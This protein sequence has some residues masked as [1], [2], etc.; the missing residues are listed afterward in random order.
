[1]RRRTFALT[2]C[3]RSAARSDERTEIL[4]L[5]APLA[6]A[7]AEGDAARFMRH[8]ASDMPGRSTLR[9]NIQAL[10]DQADVTSSV[11]LRRLSNGAAEVDWYMQVRSKATLAVL[12]R[13]RTIVT[14]EILQGRIK[15]LAPLSHFA[16]PRG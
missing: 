1:M 7:L 15:S 6:A 3:C 11:E 12:E 16:P 5:V 4:E 9:A 10:V 8:I 14:V 13:R 2:L